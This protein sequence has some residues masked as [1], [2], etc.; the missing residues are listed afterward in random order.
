MIKRFF[1][2]IFVKPGLAKDTAGNA[3]PTPYHVAKPEIWGQK[4]HRINRHLVS[5]NAI[6]VCET[7][8]DKG[9]KAFVVGGAVRDLLLGMRPKDFDVATDA[10]P[11]QVQRLFRRA[12]IIGRRFQIVHVMFGPETIEVSTFRA[13]ASASS[14][15]D[16]HG[17]VLRDNEFGKQDE[18]ATRRDFTVN[19][20]YYDPR[21][22][23]VWDYHHGM[24][25]LRAKT[26]RMIGEPSQRY[27]EDPVRMLRS[28]RFAAKLNFTVEPSTYAPISSLSDLLTNVPAA[29]LFDEMLK[30]LTSGSALACLKGL[31]NAG[32]HG[33]VFPLLDAILSDERGEK[34]VEEALSRT[35]AR[36]K[37]GK[38]ISPGFLFACLLWHLVLENWERR[39]AKGEVKFPALYAAMDEVLAEQAERTAIPRRL[40][41]DMREI[42][43]FQPRFEK[44]T[45]KAP[46]R[47]LEQQKFR[48]AL[49]FLE[50]RALVGDAELEL[51]EWWRRFSDLEPQN[52]Q[53]LIDSLRDS[54]GQ[55]GSPAKK[56]RKRRRKPQ[57]RDQHATPDVAHLHE[58]MED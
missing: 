42:W 54:G 24:K 32:L 27:R 29:R 17:R 34:F 25:D 14:E 46:F 39:L 47:M 7:L 30:L 40:T 13:L 22:E 2:R 28:V 5:H 53:Q 52:R 36:I 19:A 21:T 57:Q 50:L 41:G 15:T 56:R 9:F 16:E 23:T 38:P 20:M 11:E 12:R 26:L 10:S 37:E 58:D 35:D 44:R 4:D 49:D 48:A 3:A 6:R 31:R 18:D 8:Q 51:A 1:K 33:G 45:G 43:S 55:T